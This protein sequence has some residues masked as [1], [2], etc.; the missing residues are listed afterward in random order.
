MIS[1]AG[2]VRTLFTEERIT[3]FNMCMCEYRI[4]RERRE[5]TFK[6]PFHVYFSAHGNLRKNTNSKLPI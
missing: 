6:V 2:I 5:G 1:Y 4:R 3:S